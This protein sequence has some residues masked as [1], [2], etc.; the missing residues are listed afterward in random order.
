MQIVAASDRWTHH[1]PYNTFLGRVPGFVS[2]TRDKET[3][4][5]RDIVAEELPA[6]GRH[7]VSSVECLPWATSGAPGVLETEDWAAHA[8][9]P[10]RRSLDANK[11]RKRGK[12]RLPVAGHECSPAAIAKR[13]DDNA[14]R[15][16][17]KTAGGRTLTYGPST[18]L[19]SIRGG[20]PR[21]TALTFQS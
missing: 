21:P 18:L 8:C 13:I 12:R 6:A 17:L 10:A 2:T 3:G 11:R 16:T 15:A 20:R 9:K 1:P 14:G 5:Y 19:M 7:T 4:H